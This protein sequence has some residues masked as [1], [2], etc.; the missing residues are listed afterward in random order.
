MMKSMQPF[1]GAL[2]RAIANLKTVGEGDFAHNA[3]LAV[4]ALCAAFR[5]GNQLLVFGNGG[6]AADAQHISSE[7]TGRF[8]FD[9]KPLPAIALTTDT[10]FLT[11]WSN[12]HGFEGI[13]ARQ[14]EA[15]GKPGDIAWGISTSGNSKNVVAGMDKAKQLGLRTIG[16]TGLGGGA[17]AALSDILLAVPLAITAEIQEVHMLIYHYICGQ[18][19]RELFQSGQTTIEK[20]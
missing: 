3:S 18:V 7:L 9:R 8:S 2:A 15:Y 1:S 19:E 13:F 5:H 17:V 16:L 20:S 11:A 6:S 12:D 14:I 4:T 10:S